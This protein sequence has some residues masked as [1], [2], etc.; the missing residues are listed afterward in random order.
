MAD[1]LTVELGA[2][3]YTI[4]FAEVEERLRTCIAELKK[5]DRICYCIT[6]ANLYSSYESYLGGLGFAPEYLYPSRRRRVKIHPKLYKHSLLL[7]SNSA[8]RDAALPSAEVSL[9]I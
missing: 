7:A 9:V 1:I 4:Y 8:N 3:S 5:Q 6:D 2:R